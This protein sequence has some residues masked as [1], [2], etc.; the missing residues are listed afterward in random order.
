[1]GL[2]EHDLRVANFGWVVSLE[3][4]WNMMA[5]DVIDLTARSVKV[6]SIGTWRSRV[7]VP[8]LDWMKLAPNV[9]QLLV[10][11]HMTSETKEI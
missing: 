8:E 4:Q 11:Y 9:P 3:V 7:V 6:A 1:M 2:A 10:D 5:L